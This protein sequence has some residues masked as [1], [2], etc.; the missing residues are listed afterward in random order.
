MVTVGRVLGA[1]GIKGWVK[2]HSYTEPRENIVS[3]PTW[4]LQRGA[5]QQVER[6][7]SGRV[8]GKNQVVAKLE[9]V[10]DRDAA[11]ELAGA[12]I[13]VARQSLEPCKDGEYYW[14]DL[15]GLRVVTSRGEDLGSVDHLL[16]TGSNDVM[17]VRGDRERLIPFIAEQVVRE[18]DLGK[19]LIVVDWDADF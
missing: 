19:G 6:V 14:T 13:L 18:V 12:D 2:V 15:E 3:F 5:D 7:E 16:G 4:T 11:E 1:W 17:V 10:T 8:H 9:S